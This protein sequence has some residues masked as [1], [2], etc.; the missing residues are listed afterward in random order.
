MTGLTP[1]VP[2]LAPLRG[3]PPT[4]S[5]ARAFAKS[6]PSRAKR[7]LEALAG[8][9]GEAQDKDAWNYVAVRSPRTREL[10]RKCVIEFFEFLVV[11]HGRI[12]PP[13]E[14]TRQDAFE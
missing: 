9:L 3:K 12:V 13:H 8:F 2:Q 6:D 5:W 14:V 1:N 7:Y 11:R 10:Y 4:D